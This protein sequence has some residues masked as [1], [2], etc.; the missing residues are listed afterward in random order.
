MTKKIKRTN[1]FSIIHIAFAMF[2]V[3]LFINNEKVLITYIIEV[4]VGLI[5]FSV[6]FNIVTFKKHQ[7]ERI[8]PLRIIKRKY[9]YDTSSIIK[10]KYNLPSTNYNTE[11]LYVYFKS[12]D[13]AYIRIDS[14]K[15]KSN[16]AFFTWY[17][18]QGI[19]LDFVGGIKHYSFKDLE[20]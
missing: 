15:R 19:E 8:Y 3:D 1:W 20:W 12:G 11:A 14:L 17:H 7:I 4:I 10:I 16:K 13:K 5:V 18:D 6:F 9:T 2:I